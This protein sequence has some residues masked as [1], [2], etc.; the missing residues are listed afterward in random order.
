MSI[1]YAIPRAVLN[2]SSGTGGLIV[3]IAEK[4]LAFAEV[5]TKQGL[6]DLQHERQKWQQE[7]FEANLRTGRSDP[8]A[9]E[10]F[11][12][13]IEHDASAYPESIYR[14]INVPEEPSVSSD[15]IQ[16]E[17]GIAYSDDLPLKGNFPHLVD[18]SEQ[19]S[20]ESSSGS[21]DQV[22]P[23]TNPPIF[24][25]SDSNLGDLSE[26]EIEEDSNDEPPV[27][28]RRRR[29][30]LRH[31]RASSGA[32]RPSKA[33]VIRFEEPMAAPVRDVVVSDDSTP[34]NSE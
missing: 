18:E 33:F 30:R 23:I 2:K 26:G 12:P 7:C 34:W 1:V 22:F 15:S 29:R 31:R 14:N 27:R 8:A 3:V 16:V 5:L 13:Y 24:D 32:T 9:S 20:T 10:P 28:R 11:D 6:I 17:I 25:Q 21:H 19:D 4:H